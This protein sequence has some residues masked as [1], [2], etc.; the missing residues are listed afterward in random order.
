MLLQEVDHRLVGY[1]GVALLVV[2]IGDFG[3]AA[4][5]AIVADE[6]LGLV[7]REPAI[8]IVVVVHLVGPALD[9]DRRRHDDLLAAFEDQHRVA[10][11]H[12]GLS[13]PVGI[14]LFLHADGEGRR[15]G[16]GRPTDRVAVARQRVDDRPQHDDALDAGV[17]AG[18]AG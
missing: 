17:D 15:V 14:V 1:V 4:G 12:L 7:A 13:V 3:V 18:W 5:L 16:L 9:P 10:F 2:E 8:G 6:P 11:G